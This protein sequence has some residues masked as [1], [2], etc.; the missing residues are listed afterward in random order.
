MIQ[1]MLGIKSEVLTKLDR[2]ERLKKSAN[3]FAA[4]RAQMIALEAS[5]SKELKSVFPDVELNDRG[6]L[7]AFTGTSVQEVAKSDR[8]RKFVEVSNKY[9]NFNVEVELLQ[10]G[11]NSIDNQVTIRQRA[12]VLKQRLSQLGLKSGNVA[13]RGFIRSQGI[14][15]FTIN[16]ILS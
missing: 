4:K 8:L 5:A 10:S 7:V 16:L 14:T 2:V 1:Q 15:L 6:I 9:P 13:A 11:E 3:D 12:A